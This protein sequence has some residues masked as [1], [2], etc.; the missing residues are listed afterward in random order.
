MNTAIRLQPAQT[1]LFIGDSITDTDR[2]NP[3]YSPFGFGYVHFVANTLLA[4]NSDYNLSIINMGIAGNSVR[5]L[6]QRW[7]KDCLEHK[8]DILSVLIG[9][10]DLM[11]RHRGPEKLPLAVYPDEYES[12]YRRLIR[13][14]REQCNCQLVLM[15]PFLLCSDRENPIYH[16]LQRYIKAVHGIAG[17]F[18]AVVV[19]LQKQIDKM[20]EKVPA[21]NC[22]DDSIHPYVWIHNWIAMKW[23]RE[24]GL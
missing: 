8:P 16:E 4:K 6:E 10:N 7:E 13:N 24:T 15:E 11:R 20:L 18:G 9:V 19:P 3:A 1:I 12:T 23:L 14:A 5:E 17:Q 22:S 21:E 2:N